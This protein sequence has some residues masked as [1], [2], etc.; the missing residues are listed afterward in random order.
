MSGT[1]EGALTLE[2]LQR[3]LDR[4]PPAAPRLKI[5]TSE[6]LTE[7]VDRRLT[8]WQSL[9]RWLEDACDRAELNYPWSRVLRTETIPSR[10]IY[11]AGDLLICHPALYA[12]I[13]DKARG[14][15]FNSLLRQR[16]P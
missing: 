9:C 14:A 11:R 1:T 13:K 7:T 8:R 16:W 2:I 12:E 4:V 10:S 15:A 3:L 5:I 6:F